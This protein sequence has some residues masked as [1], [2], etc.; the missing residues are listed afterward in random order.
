V[1]A[2]AET[3]LAVL[4]KERSMLWALLCLRIRVRGPLR[5]L[6]AFAKCFPS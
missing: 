2:D 1:T 6:I 4:A 5:L 3:W